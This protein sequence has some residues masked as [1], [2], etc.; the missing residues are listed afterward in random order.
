MTVKCAAIVGTGLIGRGWAVV[1]ARAGWA[2]HLW[3]RDPKAARLAL[4]SVHTSLADMKTAGMLPGGGAQMG[5]IHLC[6]TLADAVAEAAYIQECGPE[7]AEVKA[8]MIAEID[9]A[10]RPEALIGSSTSTIPGSQF[11]QAVAGRD[12]A[13]VAH[14]ANPPHLMPVVELVPSGWHSS[15]ITQRFSELLQSVGQVPVVVEKEIEGFVMNRLQ[16]A[17]VN[18]AVAL[19]ARGVISPEG[20]DAVMKHS[21]GLRWALMGP[22]QTMDLNA[23][24]G[25]YDYAS[26]FGAHY[27]SMGR[28]LTVDAPWSDETLKKIET[29]CRSER[30]AGTLAREMQRRDRA[31]MKLLALKSELEAQS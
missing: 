13:M 3:D 4:A 10:A 26:R 11:L 5:D 1:F 2:V 12:R 23:P 31:L 18:E 25:F 6:E 9:A 22:F 15:A 29:A 7:N 14:P 20:L 21:L 28:G 27:Q 8:A 19:V 17:V 30:P 24:S 16:T